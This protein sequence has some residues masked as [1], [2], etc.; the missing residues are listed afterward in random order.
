MFLEFR[1]DSFVL[2]GEGDLE[3]E[4]FFCAISSLF[5]RLGSFYFV[6]V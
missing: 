4:G 2:V 1:G 6:V 5:Y 3:L